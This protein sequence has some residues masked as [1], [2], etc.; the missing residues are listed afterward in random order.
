MKN[1]QRFA[2][3]R[4]ALA[5]PL[6]LVMCLSLFAGAAAGQSGRPSAAP[7]G[8]RSEQSIV[9]YVWEASTPLPEESDEAVDLRFS[10]NL[11]ASGLEA[12]R[13]LRTWQW[14]LTYSIRN[15]YPLSESWIAMDRERADIALQQAAL[16]T[17]T[18]ADRMA[19]RLLVNQFG[20]LK[21]WSEGLLEANRSMRLAN[22]YMSPAGLDNDDLFQKTSACGNLLGPMLASG[23]L[24]D[25]A[26]CH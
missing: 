14:H 23:L 15:G 19:L 22:Y 10:R 18:D 17:S 3:I 5:G 20:N 25:H 12:T 16:T 13:M 1:I 9:V 21:Q 7:A 2:G 26:A 8:Y 6:L 4:R 24:S 11:A